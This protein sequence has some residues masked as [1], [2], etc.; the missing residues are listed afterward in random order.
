MGPCA[1]AEHRTDGASLTLDGE[2]RE[3]VTL[4]A[5]G[6]VLE[7]VARRLHVSERTVRRRVRSLC[8]RAGVDTPV[9]VVVAA[10]REGLV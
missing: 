10:V 4:L 5:E 6:L 2:E 9:Q 1:V 3:L 8:E 7:A